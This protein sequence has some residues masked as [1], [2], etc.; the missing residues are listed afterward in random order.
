MDSIL[1]FIYDVKHFFYFFRFSLSYKAQDEEDCDWHIVI[2]PFPVM[3]E[4]SIM[5][6]VKTTLVSNKDKAPLY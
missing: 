3:E 4:K 1:D 2:I 6:A 5:A